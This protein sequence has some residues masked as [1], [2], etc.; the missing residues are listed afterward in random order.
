MA[1]LYSAV[2]MDVLRLDALI[3]D[4]KAG[5]VDPTH[6]AFLS[7]GRG[8]DDIDIGDVGR[9]LSELAAHGSDGV[10]TA[11]EVSMMYRYGTKP[12]PAHE[13]EI[14]KL[15]AAPELVGPTASRRMD[16]HIVDDLV[17]KIEGGVGTDDALAE[18]LARLVP[19]LVESKDYDTFSALDDAVRN[20]VAILREKAP[21]ILWPKVTDV[22]ETATPIERNRLKRLIGP[23][24]DRFDKSNDAEAGPLF[25]ISE[26]VV[27]GWADGGPDRPALLPDFYP[28]LAENGEWHPALE[29]AATRYGPSPAFRES[30]EKRLRPSSW[31]GSII[32]LL[33]VYLKPLESWFHHTVSELAIWAREQH[34]YLQRR[35]ER[36][37]TY[38]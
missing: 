25:G 35:I 30:L 38:E 16:G 18:G 20:I 12:S 28:T 33:Q 4:V 13:K 22:F 37:H 24:A 11:L 8:F 32:P 6:C 1:D 15:L 2:G 19:R 31:S 23:N 9:L 36:E 7:Y 26:D 10:W 34:R 29:A 27:F 3:A 21:L 5:R 14:I 17:Q